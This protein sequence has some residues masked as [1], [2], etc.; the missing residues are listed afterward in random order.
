MKPIE[1][2]RAAFRIVIVLVMILGLGLS[3][4][5][6][7]IGG[8]P[9]AAFVAY[10][11]EFQPETNSARIRAVLTG[12]DGLP[13]RG[14]TEISV[15]LADTGEPLPP[16]KVS[17]AMVPTRPPL[18]M[19]IVLDITD[20]V[21]IQEIV[22]AISRRLAPQLEVHDKVALITFSEGISP[23]THPY[24]DKNKLI[25][26]HMIDLVPG[27][28][29]NRLYD[30][31]LEA[32]WHFPLD[33]DIDENMRQAI[34]V[35][36]DS[37]RREEEQES[38]STI[39]E[40]AVQ[41]DIQIYSIG[42]YSR[43]RPDEDELRT[44]ANGTGGYAWIYDE[45]QNTRA[46]IEVAVSDYLDDFIRALN[47][48]ILV[49]VDM[50]GLE[51]DSN[52][53]VR[54]DIAVDA[55]N[56]SELSDQISCPIEQLNHSIAFI[57]TS[58]DGTTVI[59]PVDFEVT[60][61]SDMN[62]DETTVAFW[63][64]TENVQESSERVFTLTPADLYP[65]DYEITAQLRDRDN[66]AILATTSTITVS[67]QHTLQLKIFDDSDTLSPG[68]TRF[69]ASVSPESEF[70]LSFDLPGVNL[71]V[72]SVAN[73]NQ[74]YPLNSAPVPFG[75]DGRAIWSTNDLPRTIRR[76]FPGM[77][78]GDVQISAYIPN[79]I[80]GNANLAESNNVTFTLNAPLIP[81]PLRIDLD[82]YV[83]GSILVFL[84]ALNILLFRGIRQLRI[85]QI[86]YRPDDHELSQQ[87]MSITVKRD[88][89]KQ[90]H[91][92]TKK[93]VYLGRG[94][95][96]DI[97]LGDDADI[98]RQ[99][100]IIM[101]RKQGWYYSNRKRRLKTRI[102]GKWRRGFVFCKLEPVTELEIGQV[103]LIFHSNAQRDLSDFITTNL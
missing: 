21:P 28:G 5:A 102:N 72:T 31:I 44:I 4:T 56:E 67:V 16:E 37:G 63:I 12:S 11:C 17:A 60:V 32:V 83:P 79:K 8:I 81:E 84:L 43:D 42:Y 85:R 71:V 46:S 66:L 70:D 80:R 96:N 52:Q 68:V 23:P 87:L 55:E 20:T 39:V 14:R 99:H 6:Q 77:S 82:D 91:T 59:D 61:E 41:T 48:E 19:I 97:N 75:E 65:Q 34:L 58:L 15:T 22:N 78:S 57:D 62:P 9:E 64:G 76:L 47:S 25:N 89:G 100:G 13:V 24:T 86:I 73:R 69:E 53:R 90:S 94:S 93:T 18:Q 3:G 101:W 98:S 45:V 36:T 38:A 2:N 29:E 30:A 49:T 35:I 88:N 40:Q 1:H 103:Y 27:T 51:P 54:F 7:T 50:H 33:D 74:S 95:T 92:L 10:K 26:E